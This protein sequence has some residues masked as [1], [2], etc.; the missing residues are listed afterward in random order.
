MSDLWLSGQIGPCLGSGCVIGVEAVRETSQTKKRAAI[1]ALS[2]E[3]PRLGT[4]LG[5]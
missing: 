3:M 1:A 5:N 4:A 2:W